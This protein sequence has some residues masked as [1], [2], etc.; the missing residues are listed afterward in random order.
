[1]IQKITESEIRE[2]SIA[3]LPAR[4]SLPSLYSGRSLS[5]KELRE[6]FDKLPHLLAERFNALVD[7]LGLCTEGDAIDSFAEALATGIREGHSL[8]DLF[9]DIQ[10]GA[11]CEYMKADGERTLAEILAT[12]SERLDEGIRY[13]VEEIG[14]GDIVTSVEGINGDILVR[15]NKKSAN[16]AKSEDVETLKKKLAAAEKSHASASLVKHMDMRLSTVEGLLYPSMLSYESDEGFSLG[17]I[18]PPNA[19]PYATIDKLGGSTAFSRGEDILKGSYVSVSHTPSNPELYTGTVSE[20][21]G[22]ITFSGNIDYQNLSIVLFDGVLS[23]GRYALSPLGVEGLIYNHRIDLG[24]GNSKE[25]L[26]SGKDEEACFFFPSNAVNV[27]LEIIA[28]QNDINGT[29]RPRLQKQTFKDSPVHRV[30]VTGKNLLPNTVHDF[31]NWSVRRT[32]TGSTFID[33]SLDAC[34]PKAGKYTLSACYDKNEWDTK[35]LYLYRSIDGGETWIPAED[36]STAYIIAA[37]IHRLPKAVDIK[38]GEKWRLS[39]FPATAETLSLLS[40]IQ[41]EAGNAATDYE[42]YTEEV[43]PVPEAITALDGYTHS[44]SR[45]HSNYVD[46]EEGSFVKTVDVRPYDPAD[47]SI[48]FL[49]TDMVQAFHAC[50]Q[51]KTPLAEDVSDFAL[52]PVRAGGAVFFENEE[53][54]PAYYTVTYQTKT[55]KGEEA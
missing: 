52:L 44:V 21:S 42:A 3:S 7:S 5:A 33:Y 50:A 10:N 35:I 24:N 4:P 40:S 45:E 19:L 15:K 46:F 14:E 9:A 38:K 31:S 20:S 25:E 32:A 13:V 6:A 37:N 8:A 34:F 18:A 2:S 36:E 29:V 53:R 47:M 54:A 26:I 48:A 17:S 43:Y 55:V 28:F 27:R 16:F 12:L 22:A 23:P 41:L 49:Q 1:M 30:R 39:L 51:E 11:L